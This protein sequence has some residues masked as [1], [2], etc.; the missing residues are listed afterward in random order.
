MS[1][2]PQEERLALLTRD[3]RS[4]HR[5][6]EYGYD[7][8]KTRA[9]VR[10]ELEK[11]G[12][13]RLEPCDE[14]LKAVYFA[15][16]AKRGAIAF[17]SDMDALCVDEATSH[18][19]P[20]EHAGMMHACG[21]DGHMAALLM[22]A[23]VVAAE[24][25]RL[26]RHVVL[27][28]QPAEENLGGAK[29]MIEAGALAD[30]EV[31]EIY[32][33]HLMPQVPRGS[34]GVRAGALMAL[35]ESVDVFFE[36]RSAHG[37]QPHMGCDAAMAAAHFLN[38]VQ[39]GLSRRMDPTETR[40][41]T[42]GRLEAGSIR[43]IIAERAELNGTLRAYSDA[44]ADAIREILYASMAGADALYGTQSRLEVVQ[45]YPAVVNDPACAQ[46][47]QKLA[48]ERAVEV[49]PLA[50]AEDFSEFLRC[51][52]GAFFFCGIG[53]ATHAEP[54]H[55]AAFDFDERALLSGVEMFEKLLFAR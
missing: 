45:R 54:L 34:I 12:P 25:A 32:G 40:L 27:L 3:R 1:A 2:Y 20:S 44:S 49:E 5:I 31:T 42:V 14:G 50:I 8:F 23:R 4:L 36:G 35:V 37:A 19:F 52:P 29:R 24:R 41:F 30:P 51:V 48:G 26:D 43:N 22:L 9:Y 28:F 38:S 16:D 6:P 18:D 46:K 55:S 21:H 39:A 17:R 33:M 10:A 53:D 15:A 47:V 7:L 11:T 13:D